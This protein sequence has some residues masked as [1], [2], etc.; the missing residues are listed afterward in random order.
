MATYLVLDSLTGRA[1]CSNIMAMS[2]MVLHTV[3]GCAR[4]PLA[5]H[6]DLG[7]YL[8]YPHE[9]THVAASPDRR[10]LQLLNQNVVFGI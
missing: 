9:W 1:S 10:M 2:H 7:D 3:S 5:L 4:L 8:S 6:S